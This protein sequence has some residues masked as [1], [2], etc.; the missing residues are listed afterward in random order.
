MKPFDAE[1]K[2]E[3]AK[4]QTD[5]NPSTDLNNLFDNNIFDVH[6]VEDIRNKQNIN[7]LEKHG[8]EHYLFEFADDFWKYHEGKLTQYPDFVSMRSDKSGLDVT[9]TDYG[10]SIIE[11]IK[12]SKEL[13]KLK[14]YSLQQRESYIKGEVSG[15]YLSVPFKGVKKQMED[16]SKTLKVEAKQNEIQDAVQI[17]NAV[18]DVLALAIALSK[19]G[20]GLVHQRSQANKVLSDLSLQKKNEH[21]RDSQL[22]SAIPELRNA[23]NKCDDFVH[24]FTISDKFKDMT[25]IERVNEIINF[26]RTEKDIAGA[27]YKVAET[28]HFK[29]QF[30]QVSAFF[31][32]TGAE[33]KNQLPSLTAFLTNNP[34]NEKLFVENFGEANMLEN[35]K[36]LN[37]NTNNRTEMREFLLA[38]DFFKSSTRPDNANHTYHY[39]VLQW[40]ASPSDFKTVNFNNVVDIVEKIAGKIL[41]IDLPQKQTQSSKM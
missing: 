30:A 40:F 38:L 4:P 35:L 3:K 39:G 27:A 11:S 9:L 32:T 12:E 7:I 31:N 6:S 26:A 10:I 33:L 2:D 18:V 19:A 34:A 16:I 14:D 25:P 36:K 22:L 1:L 29:K 20:L 8:E 37:V 5:T 17:T 41:N 21:I 24:Q 13:T 28:P 15:G 23:L